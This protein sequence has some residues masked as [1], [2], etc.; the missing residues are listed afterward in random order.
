[1]AQF[2]LSYLCMNC[3][4]CL[5]DNHR[6]RF[7]QRMIHKQH[8]LSR[9]QKFQDQLSEHS[10][11]RMRDDESYPNRAKIHQLNFQIHFCSQSSFCKSPRNHPHVAGIWS[12]LS[13]E[14]SPYRISHQNFPGRLGRL[15]K[16]QWLLCLICIKHHNLL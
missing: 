8:K 15:Y 14:W 5:D 9:F 3:G 12:N 1:M 13:S 2:T 16:P 11:R 10:A 4:Q 7:P 6:S